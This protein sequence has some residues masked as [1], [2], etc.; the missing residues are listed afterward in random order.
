MIQC[1]ATNQSWKCV[2]SKMDSTSVPAQMDTSDFPMDVVWLLMRFAFNSLELSNQTVLVSRQ[3]FEQ[4]SQGGC[5]H[6]SGISLTSSLSI[7]SFRPKDSIAV[8]K[9]RLPTFPQQVKVDVSVS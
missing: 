5:L 8:V 6:R 9:V 4:L 1:L 7:K 2:S 3:S